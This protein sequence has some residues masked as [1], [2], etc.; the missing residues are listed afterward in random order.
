MTKG[1]AEDTIAR[2]GAETID[3]PDAT[4]TVDPP[5]V[6]RTVSS[7]PAS[8]PA[9]EPVRLARGAALG[10][11]VIEELIGAGGMG[12]V[13]RAR[14]PDLGRAVAIKQLGRVRSDW[15]WR[16]RLL[17]EAQAMARLAHPNVVTV[18]D[19]GLAHDA[20]FVAMEYVEGVTLRRWLAEPRT[21]HE[22][23]AA[24]AAAGRGLHAAHVA[25]LVHRDF[26]PDN[27]L[28]ASD[29]RARVTDFGLAR[30]ESAEATDVPGDA[31][32]DR[33]AAR[34]GL[35]VDDAVMGTPGYLAPEQ[36]AGGAVDA[37]TD[38]FAFTCALYEALHGQRPFV[39][40]PDAI[41]EAV[42]AGRA[43][44][45]PRDLPAWLRRILERGLE[46]DRERRFASMA[47]LVAALEAD[48][49][50]RRRRRAIAIAAAAV[51][52]AVGG[53]YA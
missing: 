41:R 2:Q 17:R 8:S 47:D 21:R 45:H 26:K 40:E 11:Y 10:R 46:T 23:I 12:V 53:G 48:P 15:Q 32:G 16:A 22:I 35:T 36:Y 39:G 49:A 43:L 5:G 9:A 18:Y 33:S 50:A 37:R 24:F 52:V 30:W 31:P 4:H 51:I 19:V 34:S 25:G 20:L 29:G 1:R 38:Q 28:M 6:P 44:A 42:L 27:V 13:Y 3:A 7:A 14:D